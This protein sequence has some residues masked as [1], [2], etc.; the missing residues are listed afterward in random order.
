MSITDVTAT[1]AQYGALVTITDMVELTN[2]DPV[3]AET[4]AVLGEQ[5]GLTLDTIC[6]NV[7]V[8]GSAVRYSSGDVNRAAVIHKLLAGDIDVVHRALRRANAK[9]FTELIKATSAVG[10]TGIRPSFWAIIHPDTAYDV[11]NQTNFPGFKSVNEYAS[12][13]GVYEEELG[14]YKNVRFLV[15]SNA[16]VI[17]HAGAA[18]GVSGLKSDNATNV[19]V[20]QT[21]VLAKDAFGCCPLDGGNSK[22]IVKPRGSGDD[23][24]DQRTQVGWKATTVYKILNNAF[25]Y[26]IEHG[27]TA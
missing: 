26:R 24:L 10:T 20:Y 3:I 12:Q 5:M 11:D 25:M 23:Y 27:A 19:D 6:R 21:I 22:L 8:A 14:A 18:V 17:G 1:L 2:Q 15:T 4:G 7:L 13:G 9:Y 16:P